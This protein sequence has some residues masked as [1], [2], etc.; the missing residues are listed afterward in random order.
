MKK[1]KALSGI[2]DIFDEIDRINE[3][4][5]EKLELDSKFIASLNEN[6]LYIVEE[7]EIGKIM[8]SIESV[9]LTIIFAIIANCNK[10][11][12]I[13]AFMIKHH[14]WLEKYIK[15]ENGLPSIATIKRV[16][17]FINPKEM[18]EWCLKSIEEFKLYN[19]PIYKDDDIIINDIKSMDGK[20]C[21]ASGR[22]VSKDGK[23]AK[24]N[25][26][27]IMSIKNDY[28]EATE[29]IE[30]KTNE[31]PTGLDLLKRINVENNI[32]TFD[33]MSTQIKTIDYIV[34]KH[35]YYVAPVK[36]NQETLEENIKN[37]F[38][39]KELYEKAK[40]ENY[41][42]TKEKA[43]STLE[44]RE[45]IFTNDIN[46]LAN[47]NDWKGLKSIGIAKRTYQNDKGEIVTDIRY[48]ISNLDADKIKIISNSIREEW[49]IENKLH[50]YLD[51][52]FAEDANTSFVD[53]TQKNLNILRKFCLKILKFYKVK[54]KLSMNLIRFNISM[55]F[56]NE[57]KNVINTLYI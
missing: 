47:R 25:A 52:V 20:V 6:A 13:Y 11:T 35:G 48:Y 41:M 16:I 31:I 23:I 32:I 22:K 26:M 44:K 57:I 28:C 24:T 10:F 37:Y 33:A 51:M 54:T 1:T 36:G 7:R 19:K 4:E 56:D 39:D 34:S 38:A 9:L 14:K 27:S 40:S 55:D 49:A 29:F 43:H 21:N 18:E 45:Y 53:N 2:I 50:F 17:S 46:W 5:L 3:D 42:E 8:H 15:Y 30:S 12:E